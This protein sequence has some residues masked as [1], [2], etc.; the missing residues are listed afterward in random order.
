MVL[1]GL[2][3]MQ[4]LNRRRMMV[5]AQ[6]SHDPLEDATYWWQFD[7]AHHTASDGSYTALT[8][9]N[10]KKLYTKITNANLTIDAEKTTIT[11]MSNGAPMPNIY[12]ANNMNP[13]VMLEETWDGRGTVSIVFMWDGNNYSGKNTML[14]GT[15]NAVGNAQGLSGRWLIGIGSVASN[16]SLTSG[17]KLVVWSNINNSSGTS[18]AREFSNI[19]ITPNTITVIQLIFDLPNG[20]ITCIKD[21]NQSQSQTINISSSSFVRVTYNCVLNLIHR[22]PTRTTCPASHEIYT[23]SYYELKF[24]NKQK[25]LDYLKQEYRRIINTYNL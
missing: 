19:V 21:N 13:F 14:V 15:T 6:E 1:I 5:V 11:P 23:G 2:W 17:N 25:S 7:S 12:S 8:I 4:L 20:Q 3:L 9:S 16:T 18:N 24:W 22:S 10:T